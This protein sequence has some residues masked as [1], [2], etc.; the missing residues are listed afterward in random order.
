[1]NDNQL[2]RGSNLSKLVSDLNLKQLIDKPTRITNN[3]STLLDVVITNRTDMVI[4]TE[5][6]PSD[7]AD[8][9]VI[10]IVI[11]IRK[12]KPEPVK[13][14][15]RSHKNYS[16]NSFCNLFLDKAYILN[17]ILD[18]DDVNYQVGVFT[19]VF[20]DN[21]DECAPIIT[22]E[23]TRPP[24][25]WIDDSLKK[26]IDEKNELKYRLKRDR[27]NLSLSNDFKETK[28]FVAHCLTTA[29]K[30]TL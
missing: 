27:S 24:A 22:T 19:K 14:T 8:H 18:T 29:K 26:C 12:I 23:I 3:T 17:S 10:S 30:T 9:E 1:M 4:K 7:V 6:E 5:V 20:N 11:N 21:L 2:I 15:F 13:M 28:K 16:Q 25:P